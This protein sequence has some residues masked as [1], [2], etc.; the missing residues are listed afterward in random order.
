MVIKCPKCN[1]YVSDSVVLCP[2]CG[3]ILKENSQEL[4]ESSNMLL[5]N[6]NT[7][8]QVLGTS[9][10]NCFQ[11]LTTELK[12]NLELQKTNNENEEVWTTINW[13]D[14]N[15]N[16]DFLFISS[17]EYDDDDNI[18][19]TNAGLIVKIDFYKDEDSFNG[20]EIDKQFTKFAQ[21][22]SYPQFTSHY[23]EGDDWLKRD[24]EINFAQDVEGAARIIT[25]LLTKVKG[26]S[27]NDEYGIFTGVGD[28]GQ[29]EEEAWY[30]SHEKCVDNQ[31]NAPV[32]YSEEPVDDEGLDEIK[33]DSAGYLMLALCFLLPIV[34]LVLYFVKK[35]RYPNTA[36]SYLISAAIGFSIAFLYNII[37]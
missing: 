26:L 24:F 21:L 30:E 29:D 35:G 12:K 32:V 33:S 20:I 23:D 5:S 28:N 4:D 18:I 19:K 8:N 37:R 17:T 22:Q 1:H 11:G 16:R 31:N 27:P 3:K 2:N 36:K 13:I 7:N 25:E 10:Y 14:K 9:N 6:E 34:G 15:G